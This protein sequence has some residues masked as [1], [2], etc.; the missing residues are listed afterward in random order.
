VRRAVRFTLSIAL[1]QEWIDYFG[2]EGFRE[3]QWIERDQLVAGE[4]LEYR[5]HHAN[6]WGGVVT[7]FEVV[8]RRLPP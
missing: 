5:W 1:G 2:W 3:I 7:T 4:Y 8:G 6:A